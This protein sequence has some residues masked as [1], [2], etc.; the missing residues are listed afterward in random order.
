[1]CACFVLIIISPPPVSGDSGD[2]PP[3]RLSLPAPTAERYIS[4]SLSINIYVFL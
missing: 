2:K 3:E 4:F 1:M